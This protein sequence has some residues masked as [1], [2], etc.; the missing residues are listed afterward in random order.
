MQYIHVHYRELVQALSANL[1]YKNTSE[2]KVIDQKTEERL[3]G[4]LGCYL[5]PFRP[6][7][8]CLEQQQRL[9][10]APLSIGPCGALSSLTEKQTWL[11][12]GPVPGSCGLQPHQAVWW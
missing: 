2:N 8:P 12:P 9:V 11:E 4:L 10:H 5:C 6:V 1:I 3:L 7:P